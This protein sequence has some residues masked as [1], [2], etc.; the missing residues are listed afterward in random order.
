MQKIVISGGTGFIGRA[1]VSALV[2]RGDDVT[3]LTRDPARAEGSG[4][5]RVHPAR[6][7]PEGDAPPPGISGSDAVIHLAGERA[8]GT[9]GS[10]QAK[11]A[12]L[13]SRVHSTER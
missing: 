2:A 7:D 9:R 4:S 5:I 8:V 11:R 13:D 6:W 1:V 10:E 3:L 12:I